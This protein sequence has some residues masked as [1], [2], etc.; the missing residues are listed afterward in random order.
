[1]MIPTKSRLFLI[2][3][4]LCSL[5]PCFAE[6]PSGQVTLSFDPAVVPIWDFSGTLQPTNLTIL[7]AG[8]APVPLDL[9]VDL[10]HEAGGR[11][12]GSG[13]TVIGIGTDTLAADYRASGRVS[14]GGN[15]T[16]VN[17]SIRASG[18]GI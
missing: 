6:A 17:L 11:L 12:R 3:V 2:P 1:M 7:G 13:M 15:A 10:T 18:P 4:L 9:A 14:G 16:K 8:G 5:L